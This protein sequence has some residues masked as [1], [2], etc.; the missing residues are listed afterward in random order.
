MTST[1]KDIINLDRGQ[2]LS[3]TGD[4]GIT[5]IGRKRKE[6]DDISSEYC[7]ETLYAV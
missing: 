6:V 1:K 7:T 2:E 3:T 5:M 4:E